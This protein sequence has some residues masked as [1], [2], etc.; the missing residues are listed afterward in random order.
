M[1]MLYL[2][3]TFLKG[4]QEGS[5]ESLFFLIWLHYFITQF[6]LLVYQRKDYLLTMETGVTTGASV[7]PE[8]K[9]HME[10]FFYTKLTNDLRLVLIFSCNIREQYSLTPYQMIKLWKINWTE[11]TC[12]SLFWPYHLIPSIL[13]WLVMGQ[14][15]YLLK[16][17]HN[18]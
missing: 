6:I 4:L 13:H 18:I 8:I 1:W 10:L 14:I 12:D 11:L 15:H 3:F 5:K 16:K 2:I 9:K 7:E 17:I